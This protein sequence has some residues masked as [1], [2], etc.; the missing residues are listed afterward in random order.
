MQELWPFLGLTLYALV[1]VATPVSVGGLIGW[2]I[3]RAFKAARGRETRKQKRGRCPVCAHEFD[4]YLVHDGFSDTAHAYCDRCGATA[5]LDM[6]FPRIPPA[7]DLRVHQAIS[8]AVEP[9]LSPC[10]CGGTFRADASPRCPT[11]GAPLGAEE[12]RGFI[13]RNAE[14]TKKGW[15]WQGKW[16]AT[17]AIVVA[18]RVV[19]DNWITESVA[20]GSKA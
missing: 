5:L 3:D 10:Q 2:G 8:K 6:W 16:V 20:H 7:A 18:N 12:C 19:Y 15:R 9:W 4:Y 1:I 11:C 17:Y 13:E 14:G